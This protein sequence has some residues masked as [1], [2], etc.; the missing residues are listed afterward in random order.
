MH[1]ISSLSSVA[2]QIVNDV[3]NT[4]YLVGEAPILG[5]INSKPKYF[6][7]EIITDGV[8]LYT[9]VYK[10]NRELEKLIKQVPSGYE[11]IEPIAQKGIDN[12]TII[13]KGST[14]NNFP[15]VLLL[16]PIVRD[17]PTVYKIQIIIGCAKI[18]RAK[19]F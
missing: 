15:F 14:N 13:E 7:S 4:I 9:V 12:L 11:G 2:S 16:T 1:N 19:D 17:K 6:S 18:K 8:Q 5:L 3:K 10:V